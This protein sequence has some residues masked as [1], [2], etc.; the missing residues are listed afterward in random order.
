[1]SAIARM[2]LLEGKAVSG[3]DRSKSVVTDELE[4]LG[5][6]IYER[7]TEENVPE[8]ADLI[9][10]TIAVDSENPERIFGKENGIPE[11]SYPEVLGLIS[12]DKFTIAVAGTHGKT[13]T[14]AMI[15]K[16]MIDAGMNPTVIVGSILKDAQTNF[17]AGDSDYL[18]VE[19][20]EYRR[21]FLN[22]HPNI[23]VITNIEEDHL[24]YYKDIEDIQN[25]FEELKGKIE[26]GGVVI[27]SS[28]YSEY[29]DDIELLLPG[30]HNRENAQ[31]A[32]AVG[33]EL[34]IDEGEIITSL[35]SFSGTWRRFDFVGEA[36]NEVLV[37]DDYAHHPDEIRATLSGC[38]EKYPLKKIIAVF[39]PHL[40]SRTKL[41]FDEFTRSFSDAEE[42]VIVPIYAAREKDDGSVNHVMLAEGLQRA[43][44]SACSV[45][46]FIE[47][48]DV[49]NT[50]AHT[51]DVV[52]VLGAGDIRGVAERFASV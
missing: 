5:A 2:F 6:V 33:V 15:A 16:M 9:V 12:K 26:E 48:V 13:T 38:K 43:G 29:P 8:D 11:L 14:T 45:D 50:K 25:A 30:K 1:M 46:S 3:S 28:E 4:K 52:V 44:V 18:V 35:E 42:V 22:L 51:G 32:Y 10:Y 17:I 23:L 37:Y 24:D 41:L 49:L 36:K 31:A 7:H 20:C 40:Y 34:G 39:Q 27:T 21:S 19:A 47:A